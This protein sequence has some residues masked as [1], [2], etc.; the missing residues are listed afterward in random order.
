M[1]ASQM[2]KGVIIGL[3]KAAST[4]VVSLLSFSRLLPYPARVGCKSKAK[5]YRRICQLLVIHDHNY[6][7]LILS[8]PIGFLHDRHGPK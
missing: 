2:Q 6:E 7:P 3:G 5:V 8:E 1:R 4:D